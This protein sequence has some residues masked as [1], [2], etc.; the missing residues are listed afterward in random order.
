MKAIELYTLLRD[1]RDRLFTRVIASPFE[2]FGDGSLDG[3]GAEFS[4]RT[5]RIVAT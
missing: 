2:R 3:R 4:V 1:R 5:L